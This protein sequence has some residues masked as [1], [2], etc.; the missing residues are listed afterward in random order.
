MELRPRLLAR[1]PALAPVLVTDFLLAG[2]HRQ[3][4]YYRRSL[5]DAVEVIDERTMIGSRVNILYLCGTYYERRDAG[6][7]IADAQARGGLLQHF[8]P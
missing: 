4:V 5:P 2:N 6:R 8:L 3:A 7:I 1:A